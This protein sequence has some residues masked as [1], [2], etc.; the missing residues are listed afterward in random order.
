MAT[1]PNLSLGKTA[2]ALTM[3][4]SALAELKLSQKAL[5]Y[6]KPHDD[7]ELERK[8]VLYRLFWLPLPPV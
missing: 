5:D 6:A 8:L 2:L 7:P 3:K 1:L 4:R